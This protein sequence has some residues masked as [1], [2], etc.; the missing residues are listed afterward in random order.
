VLNYPQLTPKH[1]NPRFVA[2][3]E[4]ANGEP[5]PEERRERNNVAG[6]L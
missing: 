6:L 5:L 3:L 2:N 1:R 4:L